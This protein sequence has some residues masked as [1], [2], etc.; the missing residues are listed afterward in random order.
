MEP[1]A[2]EPYPKELSGADSRYLIPR[3]VNTLLSERMNR[4]YHQIRALQKQYEYIYLA[5][6][7]LC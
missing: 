7:V 4:I 6:C 1:Q 2:G 5:A 3:Y